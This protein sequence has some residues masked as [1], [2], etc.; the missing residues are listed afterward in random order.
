MPVKDVIVRFIGD[1]DNLDTTLKSVGSSAE[2]AGKKLTTGLTLPIAAAGAA[3]VGLGVKAGENADRLLDAA[4]QTGVAVDK[5]QEYE[6]VATQAGV[7]SDFFQKANENLI[8]QMDGIQ[9]GTGPAADALAELGVSTVDASG[10]L[11]NAGDI[12]EDAIKAL[13]AIENPTKRAALAQDIFTRANQDL[14]PVIAQG[15]D[16]INEQREAAHELG[17]VQSREA[18]QGANKFRQGMDSLKAQLGGVVAAL[19]QDFA[20]LLS[21]VVLPLVQDHIVPAIR[22]FAEFIRDLADRFKNLSPQMQGLI[23]GLVGVAAAAGPVLVVAG[24]AV[25]AFA[26]VGKAFKVLSALLS[27][28]PWLLLIAATVALVTLIVTHWDEIVAFLSGIWDWIKDTAG[29]VW[30]F[31]KDI[32]K[33]GLDFVKNLFLNW[34]APGL[35]I[36][37][38]DK[39]KET[40]L[41]VKDF[42][43]DKFNAVVDFFRNI[44][45][46]IKSAVTG[47]WDGIKDAF[48]TAVNWLIDKW[49]SFQI[50]LG[51]QKVNLPFGLSFDIPTFTLNTPNIPRLHTG[52]TFHAPAGQ[53]EGLALLADGEVVSRPGAGRSETIQVVFTGNV[54][55]FDD[56]EQKVNESIIRARRRGINV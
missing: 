31:L 7:S 32:F 9:R 49:N 2:K 33:K 47:M 29:K 19:G 38:W 22:T 35:I 30:D 42:I 28:N 46:R 5:L 10:E 34:T 39:I 27:A 37:H 56:F 52:G 25:S 11:R 50:K 54:Y 51:G 6:F 8:K 18:L 4:D 36:K 26:S 21:D 41:A 16:V 17:V 45:S 15:V 20:P 43:V 1:R 3:L 23:G 55:G 53:T 13:A 44:P 24:K 14:L 12:T 48:R 40:A